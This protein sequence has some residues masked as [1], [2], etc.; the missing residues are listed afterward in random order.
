MA[1]VESP[2]P[3]SAAPGPGAKILR[4]MVCAFVL[5]VAPR[6]QS[7][8]IIATETITS[9]G[10]SL[11]LKVDDASVFRRPFTLDLTIDGQ[12]LLVYSSQP[13]DQLGAFHHLHKGG[14]GTHI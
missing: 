13:T 6:A 7:L 14:A 1:T 11:V 5:S 9:G 3:R 12:T 2:V 10:S 4:L 8:P